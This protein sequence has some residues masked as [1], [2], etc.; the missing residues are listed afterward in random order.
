MTLLEQVKQMQE[1]NEALLKFN[2]V[3]QRD[4]NKIRL[5]NNGLKR[6]ITLKDN[7]IDSYKDKIKELQQQISSLKID[8]Q[9]ISVK[10]ALKVYQSLTFEQGI[11]FSNVEH[12]RC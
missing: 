3:L 12:L 5:S 11:D 6:D 4:Y 9:D 1:Q 7:R 8:Q 10:E 2:K